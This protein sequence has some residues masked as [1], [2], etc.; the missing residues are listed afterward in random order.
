MYVSATVKSSIARH[1]FVVFIHLGGFGQLALGVLDSS[2]LFMPLGNDL[3]MVALSVRKHELM[4]YYAAMATV[5]SVL[6]CLL[7]DAVVRKHG[8][9]G[10]E[11]Y[12]SSRQLE[13]VEKKVRK[14]AAWALILASLMPP[15]FPFTPFVAAASALQYP[16]QKML[17]VIGVARMIRFSAVGLLSILFGRRILVWA[18]S[19]GVEYAVI[20]LIAI[21]VVGSVVSVVGWIK[22]SKK[23]PV[24]Q[25]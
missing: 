10:L 11:K 21:C 5:G 6:G 23:Q 1:L 12:I 20:A 15:P 3:L 7:L 19:P 14:S 18:R 25:S 24:T 4:L 8:E 13:Y 2:F 9:E 22:R 17:T 16:R